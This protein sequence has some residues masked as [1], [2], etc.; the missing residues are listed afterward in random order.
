MK[1]SGGTPDLSVGEVARRFGVPTHVLRYWE[2]EGLLAPARDPA[3]RRRYGY[4][5]L[6]RVAVVQV[7]KAAG[8]SLDQIRQLLG[9]GAAGRHRVLDDHLAEID[10]RIAALQVSRAMTEHAFNCRSHDVT[11]CVEFRALMDGIVSGVGNV[12]H[13]V[14]AFLPAGHEVI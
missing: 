3:G 2:E 11:T 5:D 1:S 4:D 9:V 6:V 13:P 7:N 12:P 10:R 14:G 8:M